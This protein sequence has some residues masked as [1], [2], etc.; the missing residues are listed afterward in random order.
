MD[1]SK[2]LLLDNKDKANLLNDVFTNENTSLAKESFPFGPSPNQPTFDLKTVSPKE[3]ACTLKSLP[4]KYSSGSDEISY[5]LLKEAGPGLVGPLVS[6]F[7]R[8]LALRQVPDEWREAVVT[9][10][11]KGGKKDRQNPSNYRPI[12]L[13]SCV[14]RTMEKVVNAK[15]LKFLQ[16]NALLYPQQ[17]GFLP[18]HSTT[19]QLCYLSHKWQMGLDKGKSIESIFLDLSKAYDRVSHEGLI[20]KLSC[21]GFSYSSLEWFSH[22]ISNRQQCVRLNGTDSNWLSPKSGIPQGT[23]LGPLLFLIYINDLPSHIKNDCSIFADDTTVDTMDHDPRV[24]CTRITADLDAAAGWAEKWGMLF[25]AEKSEHLHIG[26]GSDSRVTMKG[27]LIPVVSH[28][29][30]LGVIFNNKLSWNDHIKAIHNT[31]S[32]MMGVLR[33][34][35]RRVDGAAIKAIYI[36]TIRPDWSTRARYGVEHQQRAYNACRTVSHNV[37]MSVYHHCSKGLTSL[38]WCSS[39]R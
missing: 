7:N 18:N 12:S 34:L 36:G 32:R 9:P 20:S 21:L 5:R 11:F 23:V 38:H 25:S 8:S 24:S 27:N 31:C 6:L 22:F 28:H 19:T 30:H 10:I 26:K 13:T 4:N 35:R 33:R 29:R 16:A 37:T 17:S 15:I 14:A 1:R 2:N 3:V 39:S